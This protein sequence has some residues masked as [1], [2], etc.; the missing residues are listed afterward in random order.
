M[1]AVVFIDI[2]N[3]FVKGGA[4]PFAY[5]EQDNVPKIISFAKE[6]RANGWQLFATRDTHQ[7]TEYQQVS[8]IKPPHF[9][10]KVV[11]VSGYLT[12]LEGKN[13]PVEHCI[14][15]TEGHKIV[16]GLVKDENGDVLIP[17][18]HII[19]KETFGSMELW[20]KIK[21]AIFEE[22]NEPLEEIII[23]GYCTSICLLANA[24]I[25]RAKFRNTKITVR[26]D[27]CGDVSKEAHEA[28]LTVMKMQQ[29][30]V[31]A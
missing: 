21:E 1:K 12:T 22:F 31:E 29:I 7:K 11:P 18:G 5:P 28:A 10:D 14:E 8:E 16:D 15:G 6:C 25:L 24:V 9:R 27:L 3:D 20:M 4:L 17:Q 23:C 26:A 2:Q 30:T 19:D 13:L